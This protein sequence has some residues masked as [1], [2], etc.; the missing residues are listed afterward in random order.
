MG[1]NYEE[2]KHFKLSIDIVWQVTEKKKHLEKLLKKKEE[3]EMVMLLLEERLTE[4]EEQVVECDEVDPDI[5]EVCWRGC[6][7]YRTN[8]NSIIVALIL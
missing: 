6:F 2:R 1:R 7:D 5:L 8:T 4:M 3:V